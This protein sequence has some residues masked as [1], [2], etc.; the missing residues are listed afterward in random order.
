MANEELCKLL[1]ETF[2]AYKE[3]GFIVSL[4]DTDDVS[5]YS[6]V[7]SLAEQKKLSNVMIRTFL[8]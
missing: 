4:K 6:M 3:V 8:P 7:T 2:S 5:A 1:V